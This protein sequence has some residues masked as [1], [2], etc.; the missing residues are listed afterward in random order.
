MERNKNDTDGEASET[1][2]EP[3]TD[4]EEQLQELVSAGCALKGMGCFR[5]SLAQLAV[6]GGAVGRQQ[7]HLNQ[8]SKNIQIGRL[9]YRCQW[10]AFAAEDGFKEARRRYVVRALGGPSATNV[11]FEMP[12]PLPAK[13]TIGSWT[14]GDPLGVG[15]QERVFFASDPSDN[16]A[17]IKV[18][19]RTFRSRDNINKEIQTLQEVT[20]L[21]SRSDDSEQLLRM[22]DVIHTKNEEL[23]ST[24]SLRQCCHCSAANDAPD[25]GDLIGSRSMG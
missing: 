10:T 25:L 15:G 24:T 8:R 2:T 7:Y 17:A 13:R 9:E 14:L 4:T 22:V 20:N 5:F 11:D 3:N 12:T 19:E 1:L 18:V 6:N 16:V 23:S 21:T